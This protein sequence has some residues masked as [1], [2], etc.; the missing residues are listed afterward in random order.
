[1]PNAFVDN[2]SAHFLVISFCLRSRSRNDRMTCVSLVR[3]C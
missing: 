3:L 1:M 2:G